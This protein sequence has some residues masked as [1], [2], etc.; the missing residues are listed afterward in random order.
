MKQATI[1]FPQSA[2]A[3]VA[4][5]LAEQSVI[6]NLSYMSDDG[7]W[8]KTVTAIIC[9]PDEKSALVEAQFQQYIKH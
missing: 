1:V 7:F 3:K 9:F 2:S 6:T 8:N 5:F 4:K